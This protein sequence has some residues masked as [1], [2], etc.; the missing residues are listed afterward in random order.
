MVWGRVER[1]EGAFFYR[2]VLYLRKN[3]LLHIST[4]K[5]G[6][7]DKRKVEIVEKLCYNRD[8]DV[9]K[10]EQW[11]EGENKESFEKFSSLLLEY[12]EKF[13]L[14]AV[15]DQKGI[16]IKHFLDSI[17]PSEYFP[18]GA[19]VAEVGSGGG[20]PSLPLKI[21]RPDLRFTLMESTGKKCEFLRTVVE[22]LGLDGVQ[23]LNI[24]A[25]DGARRPDLREKFDV[26]CA[27]A[28]AR[29]NTLAEYCLPFVKVGGSFLAYK[30]D[31]GAELEESKRAVKLLGGEIARVEGYELPEG[32][33]MRTMIEIKKISHT[34]EKYPRGQGK[35][36][37]QP[38]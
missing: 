27:R 36:R 16:K 4:Q 29:L 11:I 6:F 5:E 38:L 7:G 35:E 34:P 20:F 9:L 18:V 31:C 26:C 2:K 33:G 14:T 22:N 32:C 1:K 12:N 13:N 23:V 19:A 24:R 3:R 25:E 8:M 21:V 28:V 15:C 37:K 30:G 17:L 10:C